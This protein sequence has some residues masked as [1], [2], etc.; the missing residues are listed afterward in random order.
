M[1]LRK[2]SSSTSSRPPLSGALG[3]ALVGLLLLVFAT[4]QVAEEADEGE[5]GAVADDAGGEESKDEE[6]RSLWVAH[7]LLMGIAFAVLLPIGIGCSLLRSLVPTCGKPG[8]WFELHRLI[9][10][11]GFLLMTAAFGIA[12]YVTEQLGDEHFRVSDT[13]HRAIGLAVYV[14]SFV[15]AVAGI[16]RPHL[17]DSPV[18][19]SHTSATAD[20]AT[21]EAGEEESPNA[22]EE[23][24]DDTMKKSH[25]EEAGAQAAAS[26]PERSLARRVFEVGH[27]LVG[28]TVIGLAWYNCSTGIEIMEEDYGPSYDKE[29]VLWGIVG[30]LGGLIMVLYA[31]QLW[32]ATNKA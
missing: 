15:Q 8:I 9:N 10:G 19:A 18:H 28:F 32:F 29:S 11:V 16:F 5:D 13:K 22:S 21:V 4:A 1:L 17:P 31:Y 14:L 2:A 20:K 24:N 23:D 30:G 25:R 12:V 27:R 26:V 6:Y 7:G 3:A